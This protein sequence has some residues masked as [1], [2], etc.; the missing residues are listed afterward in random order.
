MAAKKPDQIILPSRPGS[1]A[2]GS[3]SP[4]T[5]SPT[6][7]NRSGNRGKGVRGAETPLLTAEEIDDILERIPDKAP[8]KPGDYLPGYEDGEAD[9]S[10]DSDL[11]FDDLG[12]FDEGG[13]RETKARKKAPFGRTKSGRPARVTIFP[14]P[15]SFRPTWEK[16][17]RY[18]DSLYKDQECKSRLVIHIYRMYPVMLEGYRKVDKL[19]G[20]P[21]QGERDAKPLTLLDILHRY[22]SGDYHF[23][24]NDSGAGSK[25]VA[26]CNLVG[27]SE[28][29]DWE[30]HPPLLD[31]EGVDVADTANK[32]FVVRMRQRRGIWGN[33]EEGEADMEA[34]RAVQDMAMRMLDMAEKGGRSGSDADGKAAEIMA[35]AA[36]SGIELVRGEAERA[37]QAGESHGAGSLEIITGVIN[38]VKEMRPPDNTTAT[39][40]EALNRASDRERA[41]LQSQ[42]DFMAKMMEAQSARAAQEQPKGPLDNLKEL[43]A[44][45]DVLKELG[46]G[47]RGASRGSDWAELIP[48]LAPIAENLLTG[49]SQIGVALA[50][51]SA[52]AGMGSTGQQHQQAGAGPFGGS[53]GPGNGQGQINSP[54]GSQDARSAPAGAQGGMGSMEA[55]DPLAMLQQPATA[56]EYFQQIQRPFLRMLNSGLEGGG[57]FAQWL[58]D[59]K[60]E[61]HVIALARL[62]VETLWKVYNAY[63]PLAEEIRSRPQMTGTF[64]SEFVR[65]AEGMAAVLGNAN[66]H[67]N[68]EDSSE[69]TGEQTGENGK[70]S[71]RGDGDE[72]DG[73][74]GIEDK[75]VPIHMQ[76]GAFNYPVPPVSSDSDDEGT[77]ELDQPDQSDTTKKPRR[78]SRKK[79]AAK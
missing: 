70:D 67:D 27:R 63:P 54:G 3:T 72:S 16:F 60:D 20:E 31:M 39:L 43:A 73:N 18:W 46:L 33:G 61:E 52:G 26:Q 6:S 1:P 24:I 44:M 4:S 36:K 32:T 55:P 13:S 49:L 29:R 64:L 8:P 79:S 14:A 7:I 11:E 40:M 74:T 42:M 41:A 22:G 76:T 62:G 17:S 28:L 35:Q 65:E 48:V 12:D 75:P 77:S 45:R 57:D 51:R 71:A 38:L 56:V 9:G 69:N 37:R 59:W 50:S 15:P 5:S 68:D 25:Q 19:V 10:D 34:T 21:D 2:Q 66:T 53:P 47:G 78:A 23:K 30:A 58:A